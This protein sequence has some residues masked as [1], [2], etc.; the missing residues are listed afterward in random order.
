MRDSLERGEA[1]LASH[2]LYPQPGILREGVP[3]ERAWGIAAGFE[4]RRV[5]EHHVFYV[6]RGWSSGMYAAFEA[7]VREDRSMEVRTLTSKF[8]Y[9]LHGHVSPEEAATC[10]CI[11]EWITC[12]KCNGRG[13]G[14]Q[15]SRL[16]RWMYIACR[17]CRGKGKVRPLGVQ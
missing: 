2:L 12:T 11:D 8:L 1:P 16:G 5:A 6:D 4:W 13:D 15:R 10:D 9:G 7:N 14:D 17:K 3:E